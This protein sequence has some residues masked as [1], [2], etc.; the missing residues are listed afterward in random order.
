MT[1]AVDW[2]RCSVRPAGV[3]AAIL[4]ATM[5]PALSE[6]PSL[7]PD[8]LVRQ[9]LA[10][11]LAA[12]KNVPSSDREGRE[13][14]LL[15]AKQ[16]I[17]PHVDFARMTRLAVGRAWRSADTRQREA[18]IAQ[19]GS[20]ITRVYSVAIDA[21]DGHEIQVDRVRLAPGDDD[22]IVRSR[23]KKTGAEPVEVNY[24]MWKSVQ[25]WKV[26]DIVV[27]NLSLVITSRSQFGE[28]V[29]RGGIDGLIRTLAEKNRAPTR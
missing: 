29:T 12:I 6:D 14:A 8:V 24:F 21:Y 1:C 7:A 2:T 19:F 25:G 23:F 27:E 15:L 11:V 26:Y 17:L 22:V 10:D 3:V 18:L 28:E 5:L 9:V 16:K 4:I 20:L 13:K